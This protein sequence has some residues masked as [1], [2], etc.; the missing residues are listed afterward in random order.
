[1]FQ[2]AIKLPRPIWKQ[3]HTLTYDNV[4]YTYVF[5]PHLFCISLLMYYF[6]PF[7][8]INICARFIL[9]IVIPIISVF[10]RHLC[11]NFTLYSIHPLYFPRISFGEHDAVH[12]PMHA[13]LIRQL[14]L[15][16]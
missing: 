7:I 9:L 5:S 13:A 2:M 15:R 8:L 12:A 4:T 3:K 11:H 6:S 16:L 1:M 10:S 14:V